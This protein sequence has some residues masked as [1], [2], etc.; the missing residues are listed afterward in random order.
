MR[1]HNA[2][3]RGAR[4]A[5][6][7]L[8]HFTDRPALA[9]QLRGAVADHA[10]IR[11]E[12]HAHGVQLIS[13]GKQEQVRLA[14]RIRRAARAPRIVLVDDA[15]APT[16]RERRDALGAPFFV[17]GQATVGHVRARVLPSGREAAECLQRLGC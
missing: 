2:L 15:S 13:E 4:F 3:H 5:R 17:G 16:R 8:K 10:I 6:V 11:A 9:R 12:R 7:V 1:L 14:P